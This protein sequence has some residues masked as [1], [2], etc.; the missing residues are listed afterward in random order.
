MFGEGRGGSVGELRLVFFHERKEVMDHAMP[1]GLPG[2][3]TSH[4]HH[5]D[6]THYWKSITLYT[7]LNLFW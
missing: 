4:N 1:L 2:A 5:E 6:I 3:P 7:L